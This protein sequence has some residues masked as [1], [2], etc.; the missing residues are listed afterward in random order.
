MLCTHPLKIL[1]NAIGN[2]KFHK[3]KYIMICYSKSHNL[4]KQKMSKKL[5]AMTTDYSF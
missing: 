4:K 2:I 1:R 5:I 3:P